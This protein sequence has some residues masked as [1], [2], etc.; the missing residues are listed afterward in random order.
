MLTASIIGIGHNSLEMPLSESIKIVAPASTS[1]IANFFKSNK[2]SSKE[3]FLLMLKRVSN[4]E[5]LNE[6]DF[7]LLIHENSLLVKAG[8]SKNK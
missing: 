3:L 4:L 7:K 1:L 5:T 2:D 6:D 8:E